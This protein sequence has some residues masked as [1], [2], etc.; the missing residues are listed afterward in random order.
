MSRTIKLKF[1]DEEYQKILEVAWRNGCSGNGPA[2]M[3]VGMV[4]RQAIGLIDDVHGVVVP[5]DRIEYE[6]I[7]Y[8]GEV[9]GHAGPDFAVKVLHY[10]IFQIM[11]RH[12]LSEA[13]KNEFRKRYAEKYH[14]LAFVDTSGKGEKNGISQDVG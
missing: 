9:K 4:V 14:P 6:L 8:Y 3:Y 10:S 2:A 1:S 5:L 7:N 13:Q 12:P 11:S